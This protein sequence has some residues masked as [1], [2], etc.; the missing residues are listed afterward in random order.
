MS[1]ASLPSSANPKY[2][3]SGKLYTTTICSEPSE[4]ELEIND[5]YGD[6]ICCSYGRGRVTIKLSDAMVFDEEGDYGDGKTFS[7]GQCETAPVPSPCVT[8][9]EFWKIEEDVIH[10]MYLKPDLPKTLIELWAEDNPDLLPK[11][12]RAKGA[13]YNFGYNLP[14]SQEQEHW[15]KKGIAMF[16]FETCRRTRKGTDFIVGDCPS[17]YYND[18]FGACWKSCP[19]WMVSC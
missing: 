1:I 13:V 9:S 5:S 6:G 10:A 7:F 19:E 12:R 18:R 15:V 16:S 2:S 17:G 8:G 11:R 3:S 4:F 14:W